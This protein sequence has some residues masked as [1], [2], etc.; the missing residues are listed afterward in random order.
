MKTKEDRLRI[1]KNYIITRGGSKGDQ[2]DYATKVYSRKMPG[3]WIGKKTVQV[4]NFLQSLHCSWQSSFKNILQAKTFE[5]K[6]ARSGL[7]HD[8]CLLRHPIPANWLAIFDRS[9]GS[10]DRSTDQGLPHSPFNWLIQKISL[11][12]LAGFFWLIMIIRAS[13]H[14]QRCMT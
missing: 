1:N 9:V 8:F 3:K 14:K 11:F 6:R 4:W 10:S 5:H 2:S 12:S 13:V 7:M